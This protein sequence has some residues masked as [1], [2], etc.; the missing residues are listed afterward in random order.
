M[1]VA[2]HTKAA[3]DH[4]MAAKAHEAAAACH[5][6]GEHAAGAE[7]AATAKGCCNA[8]QK[9]TADAHGKSAIQAKK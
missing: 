5:T 6:K 8:A 2:T 9:S 3:D 4:K 1:P 7:H